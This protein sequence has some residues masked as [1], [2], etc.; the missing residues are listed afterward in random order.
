MKNI[1]LAIS[2][3]MGRMGKQLIKSSKKIKNFKL[4]TLT[5]NRLVNKK[6]KELLEQFRE[7]E[8]DK[9]NPSL[10]KFFQKAKNFWKN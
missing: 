6:Q 5:E 4:V 1:N 10:K 3:C 8:N 2:G 9:S 7:I